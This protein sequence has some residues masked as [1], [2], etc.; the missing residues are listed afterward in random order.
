MAPLITYKQWSVSLLLAALLVQSFNRMLVIGDYYIN[1]ASYAV[2]CENK[3]VVEIHCNGRCQMTKKLE[4]EDE[5]D[6]KNPQRKIENHNEFF[7]FDYRSPVLSPIVFYSD[8]Q[9]FP[10]LPVP[11]ITDRPHAVF[12]PPSA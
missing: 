10:F 8:E 2:N 11:G 3:A 7:L 1:T 12:K 4:Q 6:R 9:K 5:K